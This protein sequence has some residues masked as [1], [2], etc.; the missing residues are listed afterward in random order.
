MKHRGKKKCSVPG[1]KRSGKFLVAKRR[2]LAPEIRMCKHHKR[3]NSD[4]RDTFSIWS[5]APLAFVPPQKIILVHKKESQ[6]PPKKG[7]RRGKDARRTLY[8]LWKN[9][10]CEHPYSKVRW[11][12]VYKVARCT[13]CGASV[14]RSN[15]NRDKYVTKKNQRNKPI[16]DPKYYDRKEITLGTAMNMFFFQN[17]ILGVTWEDA[18]TIARAIK[19]GT[20]FSGSSFSWYRNHF[21]QQFMSRKEVKV[22]GRGDKKKKLHGKKHDKKGVTKEVTKKATK[23]VAKKGKSKET[24]QSIVLAYFDLVGPEKATFEKT[25]ARVLKVHPDSAFGPSHMGWYRAKY[26]E[27]NE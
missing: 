4:G 9:H 18:V 22:M 16:L 3:R 17:T 11:D 26:R 27:I 8:T 5:A 10:T 12:I 1:C 21:I 23:K 6:S 15:K 25:K 14:K 2:Q 24:I 20:K 13:A 7:S 19:P